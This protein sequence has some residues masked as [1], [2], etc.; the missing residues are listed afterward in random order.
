M[1]A[2]EA[3]IAGELEGILAATAGFEISQIKGVVFQKPA[4]GQ[5]AWSWCDD[6][7]PPWDLSKLFSDMRERFGAGFYQLR[8]FAAG[9]IK[10]NVDFSIAKEKA[11]SAIPVVAAQPGN[12][13]SELI[14]LMMTQ[15]QAAADRQMEMMMASQRSTTDL[16]TA[17]LP[18]LAG[19]G[20]RDHGSSTSET[21]ALITALQDRKGG[22]G[23][24]K[25]TLE[26]MAAFRTLLGPQ[27]APEAAAGGGFD[28]EDLLT[29][30]GRLVGPAMKALGDYVNRNRGGGGEGAVAS[31]SLTAPPSGGD[32]LAL[33]A[34][35]SRWR[36][37][38]LVRVDVTYG[39][40][41]GH[42]PEKI[43]DLVY[44]VIEANKVTEE[45]IN[46]LAATF[47]FSPTGLDD[48]A[49]EGIDLR[50]RPQWAAQFFQ[51]LAAI[52][53]GETDDL[54]GGSGGAPDSAANGTPGAPGA[55]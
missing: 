53:S 37:I 11:T 9:K 54:S 30:G 36:I 47:A 13:F 12:Q 32:Q 31:A 2:D 43:A 26:A 38:D 25:E 40:E 20:G 8:I 3:S 5:G 4:N 27:E 50:A 16:L 18:A 19:G 51:A 45:E 22:S 33:A 6:V 44:D 23:G 15:Q 48:L 14:S 35:P 55:T 21:I 24:L 29:S 1:L 39:F 49:R 10:K 41:R 42:D 17:V 7:Y 52:H 28:M 34:A 46:D